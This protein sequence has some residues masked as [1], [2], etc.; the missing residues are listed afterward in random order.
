MIL[1]LSRLSLSREIW[2]TALMTSCKLHDEK[3]QTKE[4]TEDAPFET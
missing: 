4:K 1:H 3:S 2:N